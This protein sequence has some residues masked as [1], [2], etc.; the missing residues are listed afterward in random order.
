M[1]FLYLALY[2]AIPDVDLYLERIDYHGNRA[3]TLENLKSL[4][5]K[6]LT[7]IPYGNL[8]FLQVLFPKSCIQ[9]W[10]MLHLHFGESCRLP[11]RVA[12]HCRNSSADISMI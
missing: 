7:H 2:E 3:P 5:T 10:R 8:C 12:K 9:K 1:T 11:G 4:I 6:H